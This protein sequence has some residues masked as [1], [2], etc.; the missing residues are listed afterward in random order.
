MTKEE[1]HAARFEAY[2]LLQT[3]ADEALI[4]STKK[5]LRDIASYLLD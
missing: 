4:P 1:E 3:L 5:Y 2:K